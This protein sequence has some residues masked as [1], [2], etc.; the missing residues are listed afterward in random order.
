MR[1]NTDTSSRSPGESPPPQLDAYGVANRLAVH[2][3]VASDIHV[4]M[5]LK[6]RSLQTKNVMRVEEVD[7]IAFPPSEP[8]RR[9]ADHRVAHSADSLT[10]RY[11]TDPL[12]RRIEMR[13]SNLLETGTTELT[14]T[15][16][17]KRHADLGHLFESALTAT[18]LNAGLTP[19][20]AAGFVIDGE[21]IALT[22]IGRMGKTSTVLSIAENI[23]EY[24]G[25]NIL[26]LDAEGN[27]YAWP[28]A[29][30]IYP[31]TAA[32]SQFLQGEQLKR[33]KRKQRIGNHE[34]LAAGLKKLFGYHLVEHIDPSVVAPI[35]TE[36]TVD[37]LYVLNSGRDG[38]STLGQSEAVRKL[39]TGTDI[40]LAPD[41]YFIRLFDFFQERGL[42]LYERRREILESA[43][44]EIE[45]AELS[46]TGSSEYAEI[47][48]SQHEL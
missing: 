40:E 10:V 33:Y 30:G 17:F 37:Q 21:T 45:L 42:E 38:Y 39:I 24:L 18:L 13:L 29:I 15:A 11:P 7:E 48:R 28:T 6:G 14:F 22:S 25:D 43:V 2:T 47:I 32:G 46:A 20:H 3:N 23:D 12:G 34:L 41:S 36:S 16:G 27:V 5:S 1:D 35:A 31:G 8:T 4:P 26:F 44:D 19:I 9:L